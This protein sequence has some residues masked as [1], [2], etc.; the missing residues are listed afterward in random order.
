MFLLLFHYRKVPT[1]GPGKEGTE[2][3][4]VYRLRTTRVMHV[5]ALCTASTAG[6][7]YDKC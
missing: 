3:L 4:N 7:T 2:R 1:T 6:H 5:M